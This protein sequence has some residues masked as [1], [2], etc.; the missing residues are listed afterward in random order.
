MNKYIKKELSKPVF[1][2][3]KWNENTTHIV[4]PF[5][6][7]QQSTNIELEINKTYKIEIADYVIHEPPNFT[8]AS[9]WNGG[10]VPPEHKMTVS[11]IKYVG[12]MVKVTGKGDTTGIEWSG[13]LPRKSFTIVRC[14]E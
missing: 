13:F 9:N 11:L 5:N 14:L 3:I 7:P 12:K 10:I 4:V 8:L 6:T 1:A 2:D